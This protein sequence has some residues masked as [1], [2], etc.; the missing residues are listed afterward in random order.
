MA[1]IVV[2]FLGV[3]FALTCAVGYI[4][5]SPFKGVV[6]MTPRKNMRFTMVDL[7]AIFLPFTIGYTMLKGLHPGIGWDPRQLTAF[8][9]AA[10]VISGVS[11]FYGMRLLWRMRIDD[12]KKRLMLLGVVMPA[13]FVVPAVAMPILLQSPSWVQFGCRFAAIACTVFVLRILALW[14]RAEDSAITGQV[15]DGG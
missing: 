3:Y 4:V 8:C 14:I 9:I 15:P 10:L 13:G 2:F 7:L 1:P 5:F 12:S 11:W 6:S